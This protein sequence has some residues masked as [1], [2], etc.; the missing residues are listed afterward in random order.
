[1]RRSPA[2]LFVEL[3]LIMI[4]NPGFKR[5]A[6]MVLVQESAPLPTLLPCAGRSFGVDLARSTLGVV[7]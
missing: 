5:V 3:Q 2:I 1:M 6:A 4:V 7:G